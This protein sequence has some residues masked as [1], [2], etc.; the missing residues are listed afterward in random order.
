MNDAGVMFAAVPDE[1]LLVLLL[2]EDDDLDDDPQAAKVTI[3]AA[4]KIPRGDAIRMISLS[5]KPA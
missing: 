5:E 3:A 4:N 1:V 2:F